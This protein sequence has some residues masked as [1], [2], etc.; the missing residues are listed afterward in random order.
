[1]KRS[2]TMHPRVT[3]GLPVYNGEKY[4][5][6]ALRSLV[7]QT[8]SDFE[9]VVSDNASTDRTWEICR[10]FATK[11]QRIQLF[12]NTKNVG[13]TSNYNSLV[14][15]ARGAYFKWAAH[16]DNCSPTFLNA[17]VDTLDRTPDA[18][19]CY[20]STSVIDGKGNTLTR[21]RDNLHILNDAPENRL[22]VYLREN[23]LEKQGMCN[24][25]FGLIRIECLRRTRLIQSFVGSDRILLAHLVLLGKIAELPQYLFERRVH[26]HTST[27]ANRRL[28]DLKSWF[29]GDGMTARRMLPAFDNYLQLR[30]T[31]VRDIARAVDEL[32]DDPVARRRCKRVLWEELLRNPKWFY[33]DIKKSLGFRL[34]SAAIMQRLGG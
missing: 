20:P 1:M 11:D 12:R 18:V 32:V 25:I 23:F 15:E 16:D 31:Q 30:M 2:S 13:A 17:C 4:L 24:P 22:Q 19:L 7:A 26:G 33:R 27:M 5:E 3:V 21:Y 9:I 28:S 29:S 14:T 6:Q 8:Y 34:S 10:D